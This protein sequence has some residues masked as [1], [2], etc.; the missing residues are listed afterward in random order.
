MVPLAF[1][2]G[3]AE[4]VDTS[5]CPA[6]AAP[7]GDSEVTKYY[8]A[9]MPKA[10]LRQA[11]VSICGI[12]LGTTLR[13]VQDELGKPTWRAGRTACIYMVA[14]TTSYAGFGPRRDEPIVMWNAFEKAERIEG[15]EGRSIEIQGESVSPGAAIAYV[16]HI[17]GPPGDTRTSPNAHSCT[18]D[19]YPTLRLMLRYDRQGRLRRAWMYSRS[20]PWGP[21]NLPPISEWFSTS[22][23]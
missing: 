8:R 14:L 22:H 18:E 19:F 13:D 7:A 6:G 5:V 4:G 9:M 2:A 11:D 10:A 20:W 23:R 16:R 3:A 21:A 12:H 15:I 1:G 17:L